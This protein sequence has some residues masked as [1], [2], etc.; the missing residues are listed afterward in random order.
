MRRYQITIAD[1]AFEVEI[2][3]VRG[4]MARV[5]V[6]GRPYEVKFQPLG[7]I[8]SAPTPPPPKLKEAPVPSPPSPV[9]PAPPAPSKVEKPMTAG[10]LGIVTSPMP[11][12]ILDVL[13]KLGDQV[14]AGQSVAKLE[15]MKMEND[16]RVSISGIVTEIKVNKGDI[17]AVGDV[18]LVVSGS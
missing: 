8:P 5:L 7:G 13:V 16:V 14:K 12:S 17:V 11:G 9:R 18:L 6:N 10:D 1:K 15:A 4:E 2:V 3:S